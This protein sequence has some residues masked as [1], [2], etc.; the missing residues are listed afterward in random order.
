MLRV[1]CPMDKEHE[2]SWCMRMYNKP[3]TTRVK[4]VL[5]VINSVKLHLTA[6]KT[7]VFD[8][9]EHVQGPIYIINWLING[10]VYIVGSL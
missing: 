4:L 3:L 2:Q 8:Q 10:R 7:C 9:S 5:L 6:N 1:Q